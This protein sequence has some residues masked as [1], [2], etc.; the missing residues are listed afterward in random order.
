MN[1]VPLCTS[2]RKICHQPALY[3]LDATVQKGLPIRHGHYKPRHHTPGINSP[4]RAHLRHRTPSLIH[5]QPDVTPHGPHP[6]PACGSAIRAG[7]R[8]GLAH[9]SDQPLAKTMRA[10]ANVH[11]HVHPRHHLR[12][13]RY[14]IPLCQSGL[15]NQPVLSGGNS[16]WWLADLPHL[17]PALFHAGHPHHPSFS[18]HG[19]KTAY[20]LKSNFFKNVSE[21]FI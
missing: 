2:K 10:T 19:N 3:Q 13:R 21:Q 1:W 12:K 11:I 18:G 7:K 6:P 15:Q 17:R 14:L 9:S 4:V 20:R 8:Q 5:N 16:V